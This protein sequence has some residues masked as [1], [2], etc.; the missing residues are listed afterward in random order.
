MPEQNRRTTRQG[1]LRSSVGNLQS[2]ARASV[3]ASGIDTR[4]AETIGSVACD[5]SPA[6]AAGTP[7]G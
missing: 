3:Q 6:A 5:E 1:V 4:R 7:K 2:P